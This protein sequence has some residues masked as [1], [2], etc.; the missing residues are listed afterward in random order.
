ME[1]QEYLRFLV[2]KHIRSKEDLANTIHAFGGEI[3]KGVETF[4]QKSNY[5][6]VILDL[7]W[8]DKSESW[9]S[10]VRECGECGGK[11][12]PEEPEQWHHY[13]EC[14]WEYIT[15]EVKNKGK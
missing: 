2:P 6:S 11:F 3:I 5:Y 8:E 15:R 4:D 1:K 14:Y 7:K 12:K 10:E 13:D 9:R